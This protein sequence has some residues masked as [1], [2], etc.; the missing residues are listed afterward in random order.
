[1]TDIRRVG[2]S[3]VYTSEGNI[4]GDLAAQFTKEREKQQKEYESLKNRIKENN[5]AVVGQINEKFSSAVDSAEH[6]FR[7]KT[8]GLVTAEEFRKASAE[9]G[10][11]QKKLEEE[12]LLNRQKQL[13]KD[14]E[15]EALRA[16][17]RQIKRKKALATLSFA[18]DDDEEEREE[19]DLPITKIRKLN[20]DSNSK[21]SLKN[22][23]VD[24][25]FLPDPRRE[26]ELE[27]KREQ[28]KQEWL[29]EQE[30][31]KAEVSYPPFP[32]FS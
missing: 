13:E 14:R 22:P 10:Q 17:E 20:D 21:K 28:L 2:E 19:E 6:E 25:S 5:K 24:T 27:L 18:A 1:M 30:K 9:A 7:R 26:K 32:S 12:N 16:K 11:A 29:E 31:I 8:V 3:G 23:N 4:A 15:D